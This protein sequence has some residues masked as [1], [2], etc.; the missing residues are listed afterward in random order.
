MLE[1]IV[2]NDLPDLG[3]I[4][5]CILASAFFS[6]AETA[7][8][9]L[10]AQKVKYIIKTKGDAAKSLRL[11]LTHPGRVLTTILIF[12]NSVNILASAVMT[13][14]MSRYFTSTVIGISTG[15]STFLILVFGEIIPKSFGKSHAES[16]AVFSMRVIRMLEFL[17]RPLIKILSGFAD[18]VINAISEDG[19]KTP[20]MTEEEL[21]FLLAESKKAGVIED[22]KQDIITGAFDFD[23]TR[24]REI[25]T[26]RMDLSAVS[27]ED[28]FATVLGLCLESG[29]SRIPVYRESIDQVV[30]VI[31][32]K[33]LLREVSTPSAKTEHIKITTIMRDTFF[34][35]ESKS[36]MDVFKDLKRT[37][38]HLAIVIDEYGGTAGI[39]TMEDILEEIVGDIQDEYDTEEAEFLQ[40]D[41]GTYEVSGAVNLEEFMDYFELDEKDIETDDADTLAGWLTKR[42]SDLPKVGQTV[43]VGPLTME[44]TEVDRHRIE[45]VRVV[46]SAAKPP[47]EST[48]EPVLQ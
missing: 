29:H 1:E 2:A 22:L 25:M 3:L 47:P 30:G 41:K 24:V 46:K 7:I 5:G 10:G 37:K 15:V 16:T 40:I 43:T 45:R 31:L 42:V 12:N 39:V 19:D 27:T 13:A 21:E 33:D 32:A 38:N 6:S 9:S 8:T 35:P 20:P 23:E 44:V 36:I 28:T 11:W 17:V 48:E 14:M 18:G 34:V 4:L 26:P